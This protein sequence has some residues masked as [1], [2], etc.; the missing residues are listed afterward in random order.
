MHS[1]PSIPV[2]RQN[3]YTHPI[4]RVQLTEEWSNYSRISFLLSLTTEV[5]SVM[6]SLG[7]S[8][9]LTYLMP[10]LPGK[11]DRFVRVNDDGVR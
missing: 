11:N 5:Y 3:T 8:P 1:T 10:V 6:A 4:Q 7:T 2:L 9:P